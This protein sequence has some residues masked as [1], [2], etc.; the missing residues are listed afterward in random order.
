MPSARG[1]GVGAV[2]GRREHRDRRDAVAVQRAPSAAPAHQRDRVAHSRR[3]GAR[4]RVDGS[5]QEHA[6]YVRTPPSF[7]ATTL[8]TVSVLLLPTTLALFGP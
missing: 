4:W 7:A 3:G 8:A 2:A 5:E 1:D 6:R